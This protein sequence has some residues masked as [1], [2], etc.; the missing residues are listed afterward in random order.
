[1][2][3][4]TRK[5]KVDFKKL[6][7]TEEESNIHFRKKATKSTNVSQFSSNKK[8]K[9]QKNG[10]KLKEN[11][12][13]MPEKNLPKKIKT[14]NLKGKEQITV[15]EF[16]NTLKNYKDEL[17]FLNKKRN[18][19]YNIEKIVNLQ[20]NNGNKIIGANNIENKNENK[21]KKNENNISN[22][23]LDKNIN[24]NS[25]TINQNN[26]KI[27]NYNNHSSALL[28]DFYK[29]YLH[30]FES[31]RLDN[32]KPYKF[33]D[34][35]IT[36]DNLLFNIKK[37]KTKIEE[38]KRGIAIKSKN[39]NFLI[40]D[41]L[42]NKFTYEYLKCDFSHS[43]MKKLIEKINIFLM[44]NSQFQKKKVGGTDRM[45]LNLNSEKKD[46]FTYSNFLADKLKENS[47]KSILSFTNDTE[48][49][50]SLIYV[51][52]K[53]SK[54]IG[55]KEMPE[56][57]LIESLE[58]NKIILEKFKIEGEERTLAIKEEQDYLKDLLKNRAIR[59]YIN[60]KFKFFGEENIKNNK[61]FSILNMN[62]YNKILD[63][64]LKN[65]S[66][67]DIDKLYKIFQEEIFLSFNIKL[68]KNDLKNFII[69]FRFLLELEIAKK[70]FNNNNAR[71]INEISFMK[72]IYEN[73]NR[74]LILNKE[75]NPDE[76]NSS[77]KKAK[78][79]NKLRIRNKKEFSFLES[80]NDSINSDIKT[81]EILNNDM[82]IETEEKSPTQNKFLNI[83]N[84]SE[85]N[86]NTNNQNMKSKIVSF[87]IPYPR[88]NANQNVPVNMNN[89]NKINFQNI[90]SSLFEI[91]TI[92]SINNDSSHNFITT[93]SIFNNLNKKEENNSKTNTY[94][95]TEKQDKI[96]N[97]IKRRTKRDNNVI[98]EL[99]NNDNNANKLFNNC[100]T[101][102]ALNPLTLKEKGIIN[103]GRYLLN[104]LSLGQDIFKLVIEKPKI[105][106]NKEKEI[107][108]EKS[109]DINSQKDEKDNID[110][111]EKISDKYK[112]ECETRENSSQ[113]EKNEKI[114]LS[115]HSPVINE[116]LSSDEKNNT[117]QVITTEYIFSKQKIPNKNAKNNNPNIILDNQR[118]IDTIT[119]NN[120]NNSENG[121]DS[122]KEINRNDIVHSPNIGIKITQKKN[123][124]IIFNPNNKLLF[125]TNK[126]N[127]IKNKGI[128]KNLNIQIDRQSV[129]IKG[130]NVILNDKRDNNNNEAL[131]KI[132]DYLSISSI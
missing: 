98:K 123:K 82:I 15:Y 31:N 11:K 92:N 110:L 131:L 39:N 30:L 114:E 35:L 57:I 9:S 17:V 33:V 55:K 89:N 121:N 16:A 115:P 71:N 43:F 68:E 7:V 84:K 108:D 118:N 41:H 12:E 46:K 91:N 45:N 47:N 29:L 100:I 27:E 14:K 74:Y 37:D 13:K 59:K 2:S 88:N 60:K 22:N 56:K 125:N 127:K 6:L 122:V 99:N 94:F 73:V 58:K 78:I 104:R 54:Y 28:I 23:I 119:F 63:I 102:N 62:I 70:R 4:G 34:Y 130:G 66:D 18:S 97:R 32:S 67:D 53:Y 49:F 3:N 79:R 8:E 116:N 44:N 90:K 64:F 128:K 86:L 124:E 72:K 107:K 21:N 101:F 77:N 69:E 96:K 126:L 117:N 36:G 85:Y 95:E 40:N 83:D 48:Y 80:E 113:N 24:E 5:K 25:Y 109:I 51:C 42:L 87:K 132:N 93:K 52:N 75:K 106:R 20:K 81:N 38:I 50:K 10:L 120:S 105:K 19:D 111:K 76:E 112:K 1:M 103:V 26:Q 129:E 65:K 61:I